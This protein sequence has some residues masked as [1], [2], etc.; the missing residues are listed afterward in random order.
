MLTKH[1]NKAVAVYSMAPNF[2]SRNFFNF[3]NYMIATKV[4]FATFKVFSVLGIRWIWRHLLKYFKSKPF[5]LHHLCC[6]Y[7]DISCEFTRALTYV[8]ILTCVIACMLKTLLWMLLLGTILHSRP[9]LVF[10]IYL[11]TCHY[12]VTW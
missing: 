6:M 10:H 7:M 2:C 1:S 8:I 4:L 11:A 5:S 9:C 3:R 12:M